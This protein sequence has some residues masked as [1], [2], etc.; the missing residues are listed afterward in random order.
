MNTA[1]PTGRTRYYSG[2]ITGHFDGRRF[3]GV[4]PGGFRKLGKILAWQLFGRRARWPRWIENQT[5]PP[6]PERVGGD[7]IRVTLIGHSTFLLQTA[8]M[9]I[10]TDP[11]WSQRASPFQW[12]GPQRVRAP[13]L[14]LDAL[15]PVD[16]VFVS[17]NHYD[18]LN[19]ATISRL[20]ARFNPAIIT[21]LGNDAIILKAV[22]TA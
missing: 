8:G 6:P 21:A 12:A 10:L 13:G 18:H 20:V 22:P 2:P 14:A 1:Q 3:Q 5:F 19:L 16:L 7:S 11:V 15:P 17:H 9:N 4:R